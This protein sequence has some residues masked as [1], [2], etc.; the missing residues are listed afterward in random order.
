[1][2][3]INGLYGSLNQINFGDGN[4]NRPLQHSFNTSFNIRER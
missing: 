4:Q 2:A 1:M 3:D